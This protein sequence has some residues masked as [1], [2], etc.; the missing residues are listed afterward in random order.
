M[1]LGYILI[2]RSGLP[3]IRESFMKELISEDMDA[4][5][6]GA[7]TA[8]NSI[9]AQTVKAN[10]SRIALGD[11][12]IVYFDT[13]PK[14][15]FVIILDQEDQNVEQLLQSIREVLEPYDEKEIEELA[16]YKEKREKVKAAIQEVF[17][18]GPPDIFYVR[19]AAEIISGLVNIYFPSKDLIGI[20]RIKPRTIKIE[21]EK[22]M[23]E[24][25]PPDPEMAF[26]EVLSLFVKMKFEDVIEKS[27]AL[28]NVEGY[29]EISKV[30]WCKAASILNT[31]PAE[32][33]APQLKTCYSVVEL[34]EDETLRQF[35][36]KEF[37]RFVN[38]GEYNEP[39]KFILDNLEKIKKMLSVEE[40]YTDLAYAI[41]VLPTTTPVVNDALE[42]IEK[43]IPEGIEMFSL[44]SLESQKLREFLF[45]KHTFAENIRYFG[46]FIRLFENKINSK[47]KQFAGVYFHIL[48]FIVFSEL[49][50]KDI[51]MEVLKQ[52]V[53]LLLNLWNANKNSI[54]YDRYLN[55]RHRTLLLY[56]V[57]VLLLPLAKKLQ[58]QDSAKVLNVLENSAFD[59][60]FDALKFVLT[61][62]EANRDYIDMA[63]VSLAIVIESLT[64][65]MKE[66]HA[67]YFRSIVDIIADA[68]KTNMQKFWELNEYHYIHYY[69]GLLHALLN[70]AS[71]IKGDIKKK[72][73]KSLGDLLLIGFEKVKTYPSFITIFAPLVIRAYTLAG[74]EG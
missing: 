7:L 65:Y 34:I 8:I 50:S 49:H 71:F 66:E 58:I 22:L 4:L 60:L 10:I 69:M 15:T 1:I 70:I 73:M 36:T 18:R 61:Q 13:T 47:D 9:L 33:R 28:F 62:I 29:K 25:V 35:F 23:Y 31:L 44:Y 41:T 5:F 64:M 59:Y 17:Y 55:I 53:N 19:R 74:E 24:E 16:N 40:K 27:V 26:R 63:Y 11:Q 48:L 39:Q 32:F 57:Y 56:F 72:I 3:I 30:L 51:D 14:Y 42:V 2:G 21:R 46:E 37:D 12:K 38:I 68:T 52:Q 67:S 43:Y 45:K 20:K 54:F 6:S